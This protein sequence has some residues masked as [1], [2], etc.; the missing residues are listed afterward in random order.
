M[1]RTIGRR[2]K[3]DRRVVEQPPLCPLLPTVYVQCCVEGPLNLF[4][5]DLRT[6]N[7]EIY[8]CSVSRCDLG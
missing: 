2:R 5:S 4:G 8:P 7:Q 3:G 1:C 6:T